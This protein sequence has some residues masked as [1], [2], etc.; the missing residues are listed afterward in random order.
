[1]SLLQ[2]GGIR[3]HVDPELRCSAGGM[4]HLMFRDQGSSSLVAPLVAPCSNAPQHLFAL[5]VRGHG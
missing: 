4:M 2:G 5:H 1:M 3:F